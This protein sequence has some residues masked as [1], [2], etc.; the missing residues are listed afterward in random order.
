MI[1]RTIG[2]TIRFT[3]M[4]PSRLKLVTTDLNFETV[5]SAEISHERKGKH[6]ALMNRILHDLQRVKPGTALKVP[7]SALGSEKLP[8]VRA[9]LAREIK[10]TDFHV[11]TAVDDDYLYVWRKKR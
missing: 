5:D 2:K 10:K 11:G 1:R 6:N 3:E 4:S 9:A 8:N 7:R